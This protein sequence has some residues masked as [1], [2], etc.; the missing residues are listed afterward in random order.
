[1]KENRTAADIKTEN[2]KKFLAQNLSHHKLPEDVRIVDEFPKTNSGKI[3]K[4]LLA[5]SLTS[6]S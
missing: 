6:I 2:I 3:R 5:E 4:D 1:M